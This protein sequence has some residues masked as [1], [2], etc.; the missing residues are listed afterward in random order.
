MKLRELLENQKIKYSLAGVASSFVCFLVWQIGVPIV[1][2]YQGSFAAKEFHQYGIIGTYRHHFFSTVF[3]LDELKALDQ[4]NEELNRKVAGL[5]KEIVLANAK[6]DEAVAKAETE[7]AAEE[8]KAEA[9]SELARV[10]ESID[11]EVP[12]NLI[13]NELYTLALGYFRKNEYEQA[14]VIMSHLVQMR[15]EAGFQKSENFLM[16]GIAWFK[17]KHYS[18]AQKYLIAAKERSRPTDSVF[19][20]ARLWEAFVAQAEGKKVQAQRVLTSLIEQF[21]HAEEVEWVNR[22]P[23]RSDHEPNP[24]TAKRLEKEFQDERATE[25]EK[26][27][28]ES[29]VEKSKNKLTAPNPASTEESQHE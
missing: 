5:E 26:A 13:P 15:E 14:A 19:R 12:A 29:S 8:L 22:T 3:R 28:L 27:D 18:L 11:Y 24:T 21:P 1:K 10:E 4:E 25:E 23:A 6:K 7:T 9:G 2:E 20:K 16:C 17:L